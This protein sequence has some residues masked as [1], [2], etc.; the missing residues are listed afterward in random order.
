MRSRGGELKVSLDDAISET[1][2]PKS[3]AA[4]RLSAARDQYLK[5][6]G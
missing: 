6:T 2:R 3:T 1:G 5:E 4:K